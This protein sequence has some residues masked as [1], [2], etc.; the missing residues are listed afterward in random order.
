MASNQH[1]VLAFFE[2]EQAA[3]GAADALR[4]WAKANPRVHLDAVG[5]LVEDEHGEVKTHK[6]GPRE[7][8]KGV[9]VGAVLGVVAAVASGGITLV[10]GAAVGV[11]GGGLVGALFHKGLGITE[12]DAGRIGARLDAGHAA[13]GAL[14]PPNQ[15]PAITAELEALGGEPEV[16]EVETSSKE[17]TPAPASAPPL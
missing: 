4:S 9:G 17:P 12:D 14:V 2:S 8:R 16:H 1:L 7:T 3:D 15:A 5:V 13:L 11:G 10:E 6:L